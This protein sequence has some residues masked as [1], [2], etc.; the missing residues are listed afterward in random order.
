MRLRYYILLG[1]IVNIFIACEKET[2]VIIPGETETQSSIEL[3]YF[4]FSGVPY[5]LASH[6]TNDIKVIFETTLNGMVLEFSPASLPFPI[7]MEDETN[8]LWDVFGIC[9]SGERKGQQLISANTKTAYWYAWNSIFDTL[10]LNDQTII[11]EPKVLNDFDWS[12]PTEFIN[13]GAQFD[14]IPAI[15]EPVI[16]DLSFKDCIETYNFLNE[17][18]EVIVVSKSNET[19]IYPLKILIHHEIIN[20]T[21]GGVPIVV[22][23]APYTGSTGVYERKIKNQTETF[24]VS[25]FIYNNNLLFFDRESNSLWSQL[26]DKCVNGE[27]KDAE[28]KPIFHL[29]TRW[30]P[31]KDSFIQ[32]NI[33]AEEQGF[34]KN[35]E[36][37]I[38]SDYASND[39]DLPFEISVYNEAFNNKDRFIGLSS[40]KKARLHKLSN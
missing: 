37:N 38:F 8:S 4:D 39:D 20:D 13:V 27:K 1:F 11:N 3:S 18:D 17:N 34:D 30:G 21:L 31:W 7:I 12:I 19:K 25:G 29:M 5:V 10:E 33:L 36:F 9:V 24:G 16:L 23:Y 6:K 26:L 32:Y 14:G 28:L 35:Y 22:S 2:P 15:N 40:N